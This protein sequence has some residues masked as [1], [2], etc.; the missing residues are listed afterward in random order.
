[1]INH[2]ISLNR[3]SFSVWRSSL[4]MQTSVL[5]DSGS[6]D[7]KTVAASG[8]LCLLDLPVQTFGISSGVAM[9]E[10]VENGV[11]VLL[12]CQG[13]GHKSIKDF[14]CDLVQPS[15]IALKGFLFGRGFIDAVKSFLE[16]IGG[17]QPGEVLQPSF[18]DQRLVFV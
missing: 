9:G 7:L 17:F 14:W 18:K 12:N 10:V 11:S 4:A 2:H 8:A 13:E 5:Q 6:E 1:M 16:A 15:E 3:L